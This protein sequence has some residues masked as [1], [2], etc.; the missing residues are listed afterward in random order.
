MTRGS[1]AGEA[2]L[3]QLGRVDALRAAR[4][5]DPLLAGQVLAVKSFQARR[6]SR[7]YA[8]L[9]TDARYQG[10]TRF[11]LEE[12]YG[13]QEFGSRDAQFARVVPALVRLFPQDIVATV[14]DLGALHALSEALDQAMA[15]A[16]GQTALDA[17]AY[18]EAWQQVGMPSQRE[19]QIVLTLAIGQALDRYTRNAVLRATLRMMRRPAASAGLGE[20]QRFLESGFDT[21]AAMRGAQDFL[22]TVAQRERR[23]A[24]AL[25]ADAAVVTLRDRANLLPEALGPL[26]QLP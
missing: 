24:D 12:L 4:Q 5:A 22:A 26:G 21:F 14:A 11:F 7:T 17:A 18:V 25:F 15:L 2:I 8:D 9:L 6:F 20:L 23:L 16:L 13:P 19:Q 1:Q 3:K 10:A